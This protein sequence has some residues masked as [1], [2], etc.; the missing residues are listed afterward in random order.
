[1]TLNE[2]KNKIWKIL[3][4]Y[5]T[6]RQ[7]VVEDVKIGVLHKATLLGVFIYLLVSIITSHAYMKKEPPAVSINSWNGAGDALANWAAYRSGTEPAPWYCNNSATQYVYGPG[8][9]YFDNQCDFNASM[10][11]VYNEGGNSVSF[12][13]YYQDTPL[14]EGNNVNAFIPD[15]ELINLYFS[16]AFTTSIGVGGANVPTTVQSQDGSRQKKFA[17][18]EAIGISMGELLDMAGVSLD[19]RHPKSGGQPPPAGMQWPLWRM[20]GVSIMMEMEYMNFRSERPFDFSTELVI[21]VSAAENVWTSRGQR[22]QMKRVNGEL[23]RFQRYVQ[24][25]SVAFLPSGNLGKPDAFT[26]VMNIAVGIAIFGVT[27]VIVDMIGKWILEEFYQKKMFDADQWATIQNAS[28][29]LQNV[30]K[31][32]IVEPKPQGDGSLQNPMHPSQKT[33]ASS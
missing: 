33:G 20:T 31:T 27:K 11:D 18:D 2:L 1:M 24:V 9:T 25:L 21:R 8:F 13:T 17:K 29:E 10:G 3:I 12:V 14:E 23:M 6:E 30:N 19:A 22:I 16:H 15:T 28:I 5:K 4:T 32:R 7:V 26:A